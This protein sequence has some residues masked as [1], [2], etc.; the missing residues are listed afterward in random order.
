[1]LLHARRGRDPIGAG[2]GAGAVVRVLQTDVR[3]KQ[4]V[5]ALQRLQLAVDILNLARLVADYTPPPTQASTP[6]PMALVICVVLIHIGRGHQRHTGVVE[7]GKVVG[8]VVE[9][10]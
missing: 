4:P 10:R 8:S 1:M 5:L 9:F 6:P 7:A 3:P 2:A